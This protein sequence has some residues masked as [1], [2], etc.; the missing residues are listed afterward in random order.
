M[1]RVY[2]V[3]DRQTDDIIMPR[4][5]GKK[6]KVVVMAAAATAVVVEN[7]KER[8]KPAAMYYEEQRYIVTQNRNRN[9]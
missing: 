7:R 8:L 1:P 4:A 6:L 9:A 5:I 3:T 2:T